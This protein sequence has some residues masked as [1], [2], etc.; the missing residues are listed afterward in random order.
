[1][2]TPNEKRI[3]KALS[4]TTQ[5]SF[6][7]NPLEEAL[8][9]LEDLHKIE[10]WLD[11][12]ALSEEGIN[13]DTQIT[14]VLTGSSL[15]SALRLMPEPLGLTYI[16]EDEVMKITTQAKA[17][18]KM[19]TRVYPVADLVIPIMPPMGM[20]G[21]MMGGMGGGMGGMGGGMGMGGMG[22]GMGMGGMGGGMGG[23]M[24]IFAVEDALNIG[25]EK[26]ARA[27][28]SVAKAEAAPARAT[29]EAES[30]R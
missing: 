2:S 16:I 23:G 24:A 8:S 25:T 28:A 30:R 15:R 20:G 13:T 11:K 27:K 17:D 9:Y 5:V 18:E 26:A 14:L 19:S 22:G 4:D 7:D 1:R 6:T 10:I 29:N 3:Q 12:A 21:G